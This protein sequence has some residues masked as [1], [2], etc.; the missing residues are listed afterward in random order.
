MLLRDKKL[1]PFTGIAGTKLA[2]NCTQALGMS[3]INTSHNLQHVKATKQR[4]GTMWQF[5]KKP[6]QDKI[7]VS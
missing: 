1:H 3:Q 2:I 6:K 7:I 5:S 4:L